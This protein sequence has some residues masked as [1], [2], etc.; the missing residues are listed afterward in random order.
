VH[1]GTPPQPFNVILDTGSANFWVYSKEC[2]SPACLAHHQF[3]ADQSATYS[4]NKTTF[5]VKVC[6]GAGMR[7]RERES[8]ENKGER[9]GR[10]GDF[11]FILLMFLFLFAFSHYSHCCSTEAVASMEFCARTTS[12]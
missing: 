6:L 4:T 5:F 1:V 7:E 3:S 8:Y 11:I 10:G 12:S 9:R 2:T